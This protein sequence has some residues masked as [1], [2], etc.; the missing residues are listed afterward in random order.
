M[1][2]PGTV[3][4]LRY[5]FRLDPAEYARAVTALAKW[6]PWRFLSLGLAAV[7]FVPIVAYAIT[8]DKR[9]IQPGAAIPFLA[10]PILAYLFG[11]PW[12]QRFRVRRAQNGAPLLREE[13]VYE[14]SGTGLNTQA[15]PASGH[16]GWPG[17]LRIRENPEFYFFYYSDKCAY[18]LPKRLVADEAESRALRTLIREHAPDKGVHLARDSDSDV[19][20]T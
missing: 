18:Y 4:S 10:L 1:T 12:G 14:F 11:G 17:M 20:V 16:L 9:W 8:D 3:A 13:F 7:P 2:D 15:G 19:A 5:R 6:S